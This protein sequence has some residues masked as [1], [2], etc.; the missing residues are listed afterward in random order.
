MS[1]EVITMG[2]LGIDLYPEAGAIVVTRRQEL[3]AH[4]ARAANASLISGPNTPYS[5]RG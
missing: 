3:N 2:R 5:P 1:F 4:E